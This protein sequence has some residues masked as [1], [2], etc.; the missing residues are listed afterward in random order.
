MKFRFP[1]LFL[2]ILTTKKKSDTI[3]LCETIQQ[4]KKK[5]K[6]YMT[7]TN[8]PNMCTLP[9]NYNCKMAKKNCKFVTNKKKKR[10]YMTHTHIP[11]AI[12]TTTT[13]TTT[14]WSEYD[15]HEWN[16][17]NQ[18]LVS[19]CVNEKKCTD[20]NLW[21]FNSHYFTITWCYTHDDDVDACIYNWSRKPRIL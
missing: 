10:N 12:T 18:I 3:S 14:N 6:F 20:T 15:R 2:E 8:T 19:V 4:T 7:H 1:E 11:T 16:G 9:K 5:T 21:Q 13:T 17:T